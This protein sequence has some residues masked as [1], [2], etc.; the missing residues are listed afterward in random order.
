M[1]CDGHGRAPKGE[2]D[3]MGERVNREASW[4]LVLAGSCF[5]LVFGVLGVLVLVDV[6]KA[7]LGIIA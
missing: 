5:V 7:I 2:G 4:Q 6:V 3:L 1:G